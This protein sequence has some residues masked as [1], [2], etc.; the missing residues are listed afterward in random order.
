MSQSRGRIAVRVYWLAALL[1]ILSCSSLLF[2]GY[3]AS[4]FAD[5][6][7]AKNETQIFKNAIRDR[8]LL[9]ARDQLSLARWD[10]A[11]SNITHNVD[12]D[13]IRKEFFG[14]HWHDF[15]IDR[16]YIVSPNDTI[17]AT[18]KEDE[19]DFTN[20]PLKA[21]T[22]LK[23]LAD[24]TRERFEKNRIKI[25]D[26][27]G[28]K[29]ITA[30]EVNNITELAYAKIDGESM[31]LSAMAIVPD[32]GEV[33]L[34][35]EPPVILISGKIIDQKF[36]NNLSAPLSLNDIQFLKEANS[37]L[38]RTTHTLLD[39]NGNAV[40]HFSWVAQ[41]PGQEIWSLVVPIV[42]VLGGFLTF[43][44]YMVSRRIAR[45]SQSL[46]ES[47]RINRHNARHDAL[48][49]LMNRLA[50]SE[51]LAEALMGLPGK[52][53]A[54]IGCDLDRFKA[55]NDTYGHGGG[56]IVIKQ[57]AERL[58]EAVGES[59]VVGRIGGDEF[60]ILITGPVTYDTLD[61]LSSQILSIFRTPIEIA[62]GVSTE[63]G[64][65]LGIVLAQEVGIGEIDLVNAADKALY[66]A[67]ENGRNQA[68]FASPLLEDQNV[69]TSVPS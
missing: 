62:Q 30:T 45:L 49:G 63:I 48:T 28:Q 3:V 25:A 20:E 56:D 69:G 8:K 65:S 51:Y 26:G 13:F 39:P 24:R 37:A 53:F 18:A 32:E 58:I 9:I 5:Q 41:T 66:T 55:V 4:S 67:K 40:G 34:T 59:G 1:I 14:P 61:T 44:A 47:E 33:V 12:Q 11:V 15:G 64:I 21:G 2:V 6:Q 17:L 43:A 46:E 27:F 22:V 10:K 54:L 68:V 19:V 38:Q 7:A 52:P 16:A 31:L 42:F 23:Q 57:V 50:F 29:A 60:I 36:I 35:A